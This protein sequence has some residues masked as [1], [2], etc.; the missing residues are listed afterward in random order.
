MSSVGGQ[1]TAAKSKSGRAI[2]ASGRGRYPIPCQTRGM[3]AELRDGAGT[4][5]GRGPP[6]RLPVLLLAK[7]RV[8]QALREAELAHALGR[9]LDRLAGLGIPADPRLA[10]G[11]D[12]LAEARQDERAALLRFPGRERERL[13]ED[14]LDLLPGEAGLLRKVRDRRSLRHRLRHR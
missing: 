4:A 11:E 8:L 1:G 5:V 10:V 2:A 9:D 13:V 14:T 6:A 3:V 12:Q 7:H